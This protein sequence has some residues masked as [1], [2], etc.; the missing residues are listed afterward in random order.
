MI[1]ALLGLLL[2]LASAAGGFTLATEAGA[3][4]LVPRL[5]ADVPGLSVQSVSGRLLGG[6]ELEEVRRD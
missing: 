5:L 4:W 1:Q 6:I 3:R 2:L